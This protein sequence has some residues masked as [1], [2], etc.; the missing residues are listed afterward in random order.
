MSQRGAILRGTGQC[1]RQ[2]N[3]SSSALGCQAQRTLDFNGQHQ[4]LKQAGRVDVI[5]TR[6]VDYTNEVA[7]FSIWVVQKGVQLSDLT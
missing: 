6:L 4:L 7:C 5:L 1:H 2:P 3:F